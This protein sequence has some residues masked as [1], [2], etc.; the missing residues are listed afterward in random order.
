MSDNTFKLLCLTYILL[1]LVIIVVVLIILRGHKKK[2]YAEVLDVLEREK[3]LIIDS[4]ILNEL[5]KVESMIN[6][7]EIEN[8][9][10]E[11]KRRFDEIK[12][13]DIPALTDYLIDI[14]NK[15]ATKQYKEIEPT[16]AKVELSIYHVKTK[17][18]YLLDEIRDLTLSEERNR[19]TITKLKVKYRNIMNTYHENEN[20]YS[21][22]KK[23]VELQFETIDKL[24]GA[25][26]VAMENHSFSDSAKIIKALDDSVNNLDL[27]MDESPEII[28]LGSKLIPKKIVDV[29]NIYEKMVKDGYNLDY[30]SIEYNIDEA[31]KK[32]ADVFDRLNVLNLEDSIL[33][34]KVVSSY[35]DNIYNDFDRERLAR[36]AFTD[37]GR[38]IVIK[39]QR[40]EEISDKLLSKIDKIK[41]HFVMKDSDIRNL[42][43][44]A[45]AIRGIEEDYDMLISSAKNRSFAYS[46]LAK[47]M[48]N[49]NNRLIKV[50]ENL[51]ETLRLINGYKEDEKRAKEQLDEIK[52]IIKSSKEKINDFKLPTVPKK[53]Y[54]EAE[55]ATEAI[56]EMIKEVEKKPLDIETLNTRVDTAR[57]LTLKLY[58]TTNNIVKTASMSENAIVYGNRYRSSSE[59]VD[60]A[61]EEAEKLFYLGNFTACL[62]KALNAINIIEPGIQEKL[63]KDFEEKNLNENI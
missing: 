27:V 2:K 25:F 59:K 37:V 23:P 1:A 58:Q 19:E 30:L 49:L 35:F 4:N 15:F 21:I 32:I 47:E 40:L 20:T 6:S 26:E 28:L 24:F 34:L 44:G 8:K 52:A 31:E 62:E 55:E 61:L 42:N 63:L 10:I 38:E 7:K 60:K 41:S 14:E 29:G 33:E 53:Y 36:K 51:D 56:N 17:A 3:N 9:Y 45:V 13:N 5:N 43:I 50:E 11:W 57:D 46:R 54:T 18:N 39:S 48:D 22:I 12:N 16:L